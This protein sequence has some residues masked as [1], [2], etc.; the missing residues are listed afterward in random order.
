NHLVVILLLV[1]NVATIVVVDGIVWID[2]DGF[3]VVGDGSIGVV[4]G[5][6]AVAA[7]VVRPGL[8]AIHADGF[9]EIGDG[10]I[11]V[12]VP[13]IGIAPVRVV[14]RVGRRCEPDGLREVGDG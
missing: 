12:L 5:I 10:Q 14:N 3:R 11:V 9:V 4:L 7:Q 6:V 2:A 8:F 1:V 13:V